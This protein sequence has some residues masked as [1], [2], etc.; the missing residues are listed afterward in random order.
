MSISNKRR[1]FVYFFFL[2]YFQYTTPH[3]ISISMTIITIR[4]IL[5]EKTLTYIFRRIFRLLPS[6]TSDSARRARVLSRDSRWLPRSVI[7][8]L[9]EKYLLLRKNIYHSWENICCLELT[10]FVRLDGYLLSP[11]ETVSCPGQDLCARQHLEWH[12]HQ[13]HHFPQIN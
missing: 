4:M 1:N 8:S 13:Y 3:S 6:S 9:P 12:Q 11:T 10:H 5:L 7:I 2:K